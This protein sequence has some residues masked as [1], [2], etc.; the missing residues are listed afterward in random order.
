MVCH[1]D[2]IETNP[3]QFN[4]GTGD[5]VR[6]SFGSDIVHLNEHLVIKDITEREEFDEES[7]V[8]IFDRDATRIE[9]GDRDDHREEVH[10]NNNNSNS[11]DDTFFDDD[12]LLN[13]TSGDDDGDDNSL[14]DL[15]P[16]N[17]DDYAIF[18]TGARA[19]G[20]YFH[21][22]YHHRYS[23]IELNHINNA[24]YSCNDAKVRAGINS[25]M[26]TILAH[27]EEALLHDDNFELQ[28][29]DDYIDFMDI[30]DFDI[31]TRSRFMLVRHIGLLSR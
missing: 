20:P 22:S 11:H 16:Y 4:F 26:K 3:K 21:R 29:T 31:G 2:V 18:D 6:G 14:P 5:D 24:I 7:N 15:I 1:S 30:T 10:D 28:H 12:S 17:Q 9:R 8:T 23:G 13:D 25:M 19:N 27:H